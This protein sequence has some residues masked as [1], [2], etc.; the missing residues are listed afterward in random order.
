MIPRFSNPF[1]LQQSTVHVSRADL[2][3]SNGDTTPFHSAGESSKRKIEELHALIKSSLGEPALPSSTSSSRKRRKVEAKVTDTES[4]IE[5]PVATFRLVSRV[6]LPRPVILEPKD[7]S[8]Q[9]ITKDRPSEDD[10]N[11]AEERRRRAAAVAV[12][13]ARIL[14]E[15]KEMHASSG[16]QR[17]KVIEVQAS[18][19]V[20]APSLMITE[21]VRQWPLPPTLRPD[22]AI[23]NHSQLSEATPGTLGKAAPVIEITVSDSARRRRVRRN[24][25]QKPRPS[26]SF[27]RPKL[28]WGGKSLGYAMGYEGSSPFQNEDVRQ[29]TRDSMRK[30]IHV[31]WYRRAG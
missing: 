25:G 19:P 10:E 4:T 17:K 16:K 30:A 9:Y 7:D 23:S 31:D 29:Y 21:R 28:E 14:H 2:D 18:L 3:N 15:S 13:S 27:W 26:P 24:Q 20:P 8:T 12:D 11:E 22:T 5:Q 1:S 6:L